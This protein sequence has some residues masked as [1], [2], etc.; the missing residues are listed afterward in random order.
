MFSYCK[1]IPT[2][3]YTP[4]YRTYLLQEIRAQQNR[5]ARPVVQTTGDTK[6]LLCRQTPQGKQQLN[7]CAYA[8]VRLRARLLWPKEVNIFSRFVLSTFFFNLHEK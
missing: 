6:A 5:P 8:Q 2:I 7:F 3:Q 4:V 1:K